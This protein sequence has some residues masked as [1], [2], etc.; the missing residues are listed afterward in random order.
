MVFLLD[1]TGANSLSLLHQEFL[2]LFDTKV[3]SGSPGY[4]FIQDSASL[5]RSFT[6][7]IPGFLWFGKL[8]LLINI[9]AATYL[10]SNSLLITATLN[11]ASKSL[12]IK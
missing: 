5:S 3:E 2:L 6:F 11:Q 4:L 9:E 12:K 10:Q 1:V 8:S 7:P